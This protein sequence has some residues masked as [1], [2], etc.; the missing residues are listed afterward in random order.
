VTGEFS[1]DADIIVAAHGFGKMKSPCMVCAPGVRAKSVYMLRLSGD[2]NVSINGE[3][4]NNRTEGSWKYLGKRPN[5]LR[6][7]SESNCIRT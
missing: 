7:A 3:L 2:N 6:P 1:I 5:L 4:A